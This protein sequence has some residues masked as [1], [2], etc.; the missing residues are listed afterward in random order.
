MT[1]CDHSSLAELVDGAFVV[2]ADLPLHVAERRIDVADELCHFE[3][4]IGSVFVITT[5]LYL[6]G[7]LVDAHLGAGDRTNDVFSDRHCCCLNERS[8]RAE[9]ARFRVLFHLPRLS[10]PLLNNGHS[11]SNA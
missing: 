6:F 5:T 11:R 1:V 10:L 2:D 7:G 3:L 8:R 4:C 9:V